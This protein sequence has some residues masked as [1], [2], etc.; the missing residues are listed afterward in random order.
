MFRSSALKRRLRRGIP[1]HLRPIA[2]YR[3]SDIATLKTKFPDPQLIDVSQV[4][5]QVLE[6]IEKDVDR[7]YPEHDLFTVEGSGQGALRNILVWYAAVDPD[8][9]YCQGMSFVAGLLLTYFTAEEA[10]YCFYHCL[11]NMGLRQM[12]L[13]GLVDLQRRLHVLT[14]LGWV[15][16]EPLWQHLTDNHVDPMMYATEWF[17][18]LF[19]RGFDFALSTRVVEIFMF[20]GYKVIYRVALSI[21]MSMEAPLMAA[22][23]E[24]ILHIIRN[25]NKN[26]NPAQIMQDSYTW[27]FR[28]ADLTRHENVYNK[29]QN[30][31]MGGSKKR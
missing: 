16:I 12:Y 30:E 26:M 4:S 22:D 27:N 9:E 17:M 24:G 7:T 31:V 15:H 13:P 19:C 28:T 21:L 6:D 8:V 23:F 29:L 1:P 3:L 14:Q 20:E 5:K 18:T 11:W 25:C 10:F 2:W